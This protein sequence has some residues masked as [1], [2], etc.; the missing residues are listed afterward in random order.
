MAGLGDQDAPETRPLR[1]PRAVA[2]LQLVQ[3]LQ[4][5]R[6]AAA[7]RRSARSAAGSCGPAR[8]GSP[9]TRPARP[10]PSRAVNTAASSTVTGPAARAPG[11]PGSGSGR[12]PTKVAVTAE[13]PVISSPVRYWARSTMC[14]PRSPSAPRPGSLALQPPGQ[15]ERRVHQPVLEVT[16]ADVADLADPAVADQL[17]GQGHGRD[18]AVVEAGHRADAAGGGPRRRGRHGLAPRPA[19]W[20]AASRTAR[21]CRRR[22][23]R[24]RPRRAASPGVQTS[25]SCTSSRLI[26][27]RQSVSVAAQPS[28]APRRPPRRRP[29]RTARPCRGA[30]AGRAR[31]ARSARPASAPRP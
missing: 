17:A 20:P 8:T 23:R 16:R 11:R 18:A 31:A 22:A 9:R 29:A 12:S 15:R 13:T 3:P 25:T 30:A 10:A 24:W 2:E 27:A 4:V 7:R 28:A 21:A 19:C 6:Q 26:R 1:R 5:E 14:A